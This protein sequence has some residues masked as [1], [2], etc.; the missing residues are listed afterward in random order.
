MLTTYNIC[1]SPC[2]SHRKFERKRS[3][4]I[5]QGRNKTGKLT[6]IK[7]KNEC[8][9]NRRYSR[10]AFRNCTCTPKKYLP[11]NTAPYKTMQIKGSKQDAVN[12]LMTLLLKTLFCEKYLSTTIP[13]CFVPQLKILSKYSQ[14]KPFSM[15]A[16]C[17]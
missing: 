16:I 14:I 12:I 3:W 4:N 11:L 7:G 13:Q 1:V 17:V 6:V 2:K 9:M 10:K 5:M 8:L 15:F